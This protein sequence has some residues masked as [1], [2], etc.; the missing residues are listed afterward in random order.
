MCTKWGQ[1][2]TEF[3]RFFVFIHRV[4]LGRNYFRASA[5]VAATFGGTPNEKPPTSGGF[6]TG[7]D[8]AM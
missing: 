2:K 4:F 1:Q 7:R 3:P 5:I 6:R 8:V